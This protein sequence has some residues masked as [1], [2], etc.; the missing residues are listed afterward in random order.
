MKRPANETAGPGFPV[1]PYYGYNIVVHFQLT[2]FV[3]L[4]EL[5]QV[6]SI[7]ALHCSDSVKHKTQQFVDKYMKKFGQVF[8]RDPNDTKEY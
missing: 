7:E 5:K 2:H 8:Y 3:M 4:K 1:G 6:P